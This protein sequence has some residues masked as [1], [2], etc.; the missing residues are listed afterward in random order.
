M[1]GSHLGLKGRLHGPRFNRQQQKGLRRWLRD[2]MPRAE[3]VLWSRLRG[4]QLSGL[5]FRRQYGVGP[6]V[7]DF[8]CPEARLAIEVDGFGHEEK[9]DAMRQRFIE[10]FEIVFV[11]CMN[12][13]V[14]RRID[15]VLEEI[16][17]VGQ[18]Q[19]AKHSAGDS[20]DATE[21]LAACGR[22]RTEALKWLAPRG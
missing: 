21:S 14:Y 10:S 7:V 22:L 11:R 15:V 13:D 17:R 6:Y 3:V 4:K 2:E 12:D 1:S 16:E 18:E 19:I 20:G 8:Y 5:R 9:R